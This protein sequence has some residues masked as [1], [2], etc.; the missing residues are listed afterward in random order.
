MKRKEKKEKRGK[1]KMEENFK[2]FAMVFLLKYR[3]RYIRKVIT[4]K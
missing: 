3:K 1:E 2:M 4:E